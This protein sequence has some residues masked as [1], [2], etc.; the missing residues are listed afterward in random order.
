MHC[1]QGSTVRDRVALLLL[2]SASTMLLRG[3]Q[4]TA[5]SFPSPVVLGSM[6]SRRRSSES[7]MKRS[8]WKKRRITFSSLHR[9]SLSSRWAITS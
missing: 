3:S 5:S 8:F 1:P 7:S 9:G 4:A 6:G 2:T